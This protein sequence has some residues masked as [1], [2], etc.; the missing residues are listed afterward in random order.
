MSIS[1]DIQLVWGFSHSFGPFFLSIIWTLHSSWVLRLWLRPLTPNLFTI[2]FLHMKQCAVKTSSDT[3]SASLTQQ[4]SCSDTLNLYTH[5]WVLQVKHTVTSTTQS[6]VIWAYIKNR[7]PLVQSAYKYCRNT[8]LLT[9]HRKS[10]QRSLTET[11]L[12]SSNM[13]NMETRVC[14]A[15]DIT[16]IT[17]TDSVITDPVVWHFQVSPTYALFN[18]IVTLGW[19]QFRTNIL[20]PSTFNS[21]TIFPVTVWAITVLMMQ[22]KYNIITADRNRTTDKL[23]K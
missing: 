8:S 14:Y 17:Q 22:I 21:V 18:T 13:L 15:D 1:I 5:I 19:F 20:T 16:A 10:F 11:R 2:L 6:Q 9:S 23:H 7:E 3:F 12:F 4:P